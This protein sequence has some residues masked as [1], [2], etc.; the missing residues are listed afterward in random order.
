M[1]IVESGF[2][3]EDEIDG[4]AVLR[5]LERCGRT[6]YK[7]E[8]K[9]TSESARKF[10]HMLLHE[11]HHESVIEHV[12]ITVRIICDRGVSHEIVRHRLAA[13]SQ[14]STRYC[15]YSKEK[16]G[17]EIAIS[18]ML[19]GLTSEQVDR[20][21]KLYDHIQSVYLEES[22]EGIAPQQARDNLPTCLKTEIVVTFNL[23]EW[24]H[25]FKQRC[26]KKAHPQIRKITIPML[27]EFQRLIPVVFDDIQ[28]E[29]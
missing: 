1:K 26:S 29:E 15:N 6:C 19:D 21:M 8:E 12:S 14:E 11:K 17:S 28:P 4:E 22:S 2:M 23:R 7:S 25:F 9:I 18:P 3:F 5:K 16:F 24:R 10:V 27:R 13:Y 20:R